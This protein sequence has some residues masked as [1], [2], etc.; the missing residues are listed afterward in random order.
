MKLKCTASGVDEE[1]PW[2]C[3]RPSKKKSG[4]CYGHARHLSRGDK[5]L[6]RLKKRA[7]NRRST[8]GTTHDP[9]DMFCTV[10]AG[11]KFCLGCETNIPVADFHAN[12]SAGSGLRE[13]CKQ[14]VSDNNVDMKHGEGAAQ[15]KREQL[16]RQGGVCAGCGTTEP[17]GPRGGTGDFALDHDHA[18]TGPESWRY[19]LCNTCNLFLGRIEGDGFNIERFVAWVK[20]EGLIPPSRNV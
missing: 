4:L 8:R 12:K 17:G 13:R 16:A 6:K 18:K 7:H 3:D 10:P 15:W 5:T 20:Q 9:N 19:V 14:C 2:K 11:Y 1:G